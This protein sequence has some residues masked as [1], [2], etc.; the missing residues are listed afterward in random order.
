MHCSK[1][2]SQ[3]EKKE[4]KTVASM[5]MK[6][7]SNNSLI[8]IIEERCALTTTRVLKES[9]KVVTKRIPQKQWP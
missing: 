9:K 8:S 2:I 4:R 5:E 7:I 6:P 1:G 3:K